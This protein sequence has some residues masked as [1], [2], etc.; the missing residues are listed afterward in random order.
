MLSDSEVSEVRDLTVRLRLLGG[1][2]SDRDGVPLG[3]GGPDRH[4]DLE[5]AVLVP[6]LQLFLFRAR[7]QRYPPQEGAIVKL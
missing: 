2:A 5:D 1:P 3:F 6:R 4:R 7:R